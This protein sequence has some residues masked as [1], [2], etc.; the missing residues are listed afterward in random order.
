MQSVDDLL[1]T[2]LEAFGERDAE[3]RRAAI[4]KIWEPDGVFLDPEGLHIGTEAIDDAIE[5]LLL[6]FPDFIFSELGAPDSHN[7]IGRL[8][9]GFGPAGK[10]PA[11]TG[12][13]VIV[14]KGG[15]IE[16]LYTFLDPL[17]NEETDAE[18]EA[19]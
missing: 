16:A 5:H 19:G 3:K 18:P 2:N 11:V 8:A 6:K 9:W 17:R 13:D 10:K 4:S 7:G 15:K 14:S 12:L 1:R